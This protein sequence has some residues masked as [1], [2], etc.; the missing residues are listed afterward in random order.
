VSSGNVQK[1]IVLIDPS[2]K[3]QVLREL[4]RMWING[5]SLFPGIDGAGKYFSEFARWA[6]LDKAVRIVAGQTEPD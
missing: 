6:P 5:A 1:Q 2:L 4:D 3:R